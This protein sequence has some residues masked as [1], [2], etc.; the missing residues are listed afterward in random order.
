MALVD[1]IE[2]TDKLTQAMFDRWTKEYLEM[3][4]VKSSEDCT[5]TENEGDV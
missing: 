5:T 3:K 4:G 2:M 1:I